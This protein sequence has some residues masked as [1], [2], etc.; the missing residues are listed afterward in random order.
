MRHDLNAP[1]TVEQAIRR[2]A[3]ETP[4][5]PAFTFLADG[6]VE[7]GH[8][9]FS[10]LD[11]TLRQAGGWL[12]QHGLGGKRVLLVIE[13]GENYVIALLACL[14]AGCVA[15]PCYPPRLNATSRELAAIAE[16]CDAAAI[17]ATELT[18]VL[19]DQLA[20]RPALPVLTL[21][22]SVLSN[23]APWSPP[24]LT[25]A[26]LAI[27][28]YTSGST[29]AP[30]GVMV[31]HDNVVRHVG[32]IA[33]RIGLN[34]DST[35]VSWLP[36]Y[37]DMGLIGFL[38][39][40][41][42]QGFRCVMMTPT[43][44]IAKPVRWLN[45]LTRYGGTVSSSPNFG[46]DLCVDRIDQD[47][48]TD[49]DLRSWRC[50]GNGAEPVRL[51]TLQRFAHRF[52]AVGFS[53]RSF[54]PCYGLAEGTLAVSLPA[55]TSDPLAADALFGVTDTPESDADQ[56][57]CGTALDDHEI[58][59]IDP[60]SLVPVPDG[61]CGE[62]CVT[63]PSVAAGYWN[64]P[65]TT[66]RIFGL[67]LDGD[68]RRYLRTGDMGVLNGGQLFVVGRY[69][70]IIIVRGRNF[71]PSDIEYH[72]A[73][74]DDRLRPGCSAAFTI[75]IPDG[76]QVII[77][78]EVRNPG[79]T[80]SFNEIIEHIRQ[81]VL[82]E[83]GISLDEVVLTAPRTLP[84]TTSGKIQRRAVRARYLAGDLTSLSGLTS[85]A[86]VC[87]TTRPTTR[88][89]PIKRRNAM[90]VLLIEQL[91]VL[92]GEAL[93]LSPTSSFAD[94]GL[95]SVRAATF[96]G[97]LSVLLGRPLRPN[98]LFEHPTVDELARYLAETAAA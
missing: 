49:L 87:N 92:L 23:Q 42:V 10:A 21:D 43:D 32:A 34:A 11:R 45:A 53:S 4:D 16:D 94:Q 22:C 62:I 70:D 7:S 46:Y 61:S 66:E 74:A 39:M 26:D 58:A 60:E 1:D 17:I 59:I 88:S 25:G 90:E 41:A 30:K 47:A 52:A 20:D 9:T 69:R 8:Y 28:Q 72:C 5:R 36:P 95:D 24:P 57:G 63:G 38:L 64:R 3:A 89:H 2:R 84:K 27:L 68:D 78:Q 77:A 56:V 40:P 97:N 86:P 51:T 18:A 31:T 83:V 85:P 12:Q 96:V 73:T 75:P 71:A 37:H 33:D 35:A 13:P 81:A 98:L 91:E 55:G 44:F 82:T 65:Q 67:R 15:V 80:G 76:Q 79:D 6:E 50:A 54:L 48:L 93:D 14:Y 19:L 29:G